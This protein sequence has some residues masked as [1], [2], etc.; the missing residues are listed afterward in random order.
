[1]SEDVDDDAAGIPD[2]EA[3]YTPGLVRQRVD[4][5]VASTCSVVMSG[6]TRRTLIRTQCPSGADVSAASG[7]LLARYSHRRDTREA[8]ADP[9]G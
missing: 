8:R 4:E 7:M 2:E 6:T 5:V 3:T 9:E 1:M